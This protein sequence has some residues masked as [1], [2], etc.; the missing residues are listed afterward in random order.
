M[1]V[2]QSKMQ[3]KVMRIQPSKPVFK[4]IIVMS[5]HADLHSIVKTGRIEYVC[6]D[7]Y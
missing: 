1:T 6:N 3:C 4:S 7:W 5:V 2:T